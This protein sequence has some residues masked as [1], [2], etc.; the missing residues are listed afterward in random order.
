MTVRAGVL[1]LALIVPSASPALSAERQLKPF[2][3]ATFGG[4][5]TFVDP[6]NAAGSPS[7]VY[8]VSA[9]LLG[10][11]LGIDVDIGHS[12][13]FFQSG[14]QP[15]LLSSSV[16]TLTGNVVVAMPRRL[17]QYGLRPYFV[18]GLGVMHARQ[19][20][21]LGALVF[22]ES[23]P[24]LD[25]GGGATGFFTNRIGISWEVRHFGSF[26][27]TDKLSGISIG[28]EQLSFWR[29]TTAVVIRF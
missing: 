8:G 9:I 3:G 23:V 15:T 22:S 29:A 24:V 18:G 14:D 16:T 28:P 19:Q 17:T 1:A 21:A 20:D 12:P 7:L 4:S 11:V 26:G 10:E 5:N 27:T 25:V 13:G 6:E 2:V